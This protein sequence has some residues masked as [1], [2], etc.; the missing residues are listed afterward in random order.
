MIC[1]YCGQEAEWVPNE[2]IYGKRYGKSWMTWWC[3]QD[4][5]RVGCHNN[6]RTPLGTMANSELREWRKRAHAY[7]DPIWKSGQMS[8]RKVYELLDRHFGREMHVGESD[9]ET[10]KEILKVDFSI[11]KK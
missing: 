4:D 10:C 6:T 1:P 3:R 5:A 9:I 8:R 2:E 11:T 7:I